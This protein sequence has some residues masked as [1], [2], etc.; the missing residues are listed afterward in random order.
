MFPFSHEASHPSECVHSV[1]IT[2]RVQ[3]RPVSVNAG[4][5]YLLQTLPSLHSFIFSSASSL[6]FSSSEQTGTDR[7]SFLLPLVSMQVNAALKRL[8]ARRIF[9][10][11]GE[12]FLSFFY[13]YPFIIVHEE[14]ILI[15]VISANEMDGVRAHAVSLSILPISFT[16]SS[17]MFYFPQHRVSAISSYFLSLSCNL[18]SASLSYILHLL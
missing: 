6:D 11:M 8:H 3:D 15:N 4:D 18:L 17:Y 13:Q 2:L 16:V 12:L 14:F 7:Y 10:W 1:H 9:F 5:G